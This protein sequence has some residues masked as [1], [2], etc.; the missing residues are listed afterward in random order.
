M[1]SVDELAEWV[2]VNAHKHAGM[3][4]VLEAVVGG[5]LELI[6]ARPD[7]RLLRDQ[8]RE[9]H[10]LIR[11]PRDMHH[12]RGRHKHDEDRNPA[13]GGKRHLPEPIEAELVEELETLRRRIA[14]YELADAAR[15]ELADA[16]RLATRALGEAYVAGEGDPPVTRLTDEQLVAGLGKPIE[17]EPRGVALVEPS[18]LPP[19]GIPF[20]TDDEDDRDDTDHGAPDAPDPKDKHAEKAKRKK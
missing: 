19:I 14:E 9:H 11:F 20:I 3:W 8:E 10:I 5:A 17:P 12:K 13:T 2:R 6:D 15:L 18:G 16:A 7:Q 4:V 1:V